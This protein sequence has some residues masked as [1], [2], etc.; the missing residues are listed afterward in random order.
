MLCVIERLDSC[1]DIV[2]RGTLSASLTGSRID[3][4]TTIVTILNEQ[5]R[6]VQDE[7]WSLRET[8]NNKNADAVTRMEAALRVADIMAPLVVEAAKRDLE[9]KYEIRYV[10]GAKVKVR[11]T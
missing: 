9:P 11:V 10:R 1:R 3:M 6:E 4:P 5:P 7:V 2:R 8:F